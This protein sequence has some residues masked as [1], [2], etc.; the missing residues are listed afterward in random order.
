MLGAGRREELLKEAERLGITHVLAKPVLGAALRNTM[1]ALKGQ[2]PVAPDGGRPSSRQSSLLESQLGAIAGA[3][4]LLVEDNENNQLVACELLQGAGLVVD[5]AANGK[6]AV[7]QVE[8]RDAQHMPYDLVLM[9]MQMPVMDGVTATRLL[10]ETHS[11]AV[12]PIVAMT[13]NAMQEYR[14]RCLQAGMNAYVSKPVNPDE[15]WRALLV[16]IQPRAGLGQALR[17]SHDKP[18]PHS[19]LPP[20]LAAA[21]AVDVPQEAQAALEETLQAAKMGGGE[22]RA[23]EPAA[24]KIRALLA[25]E[26]PQLA[27]LWS[28]HVSALRPAPDD[29]GTQAP[30]AYNQ[31]QFRST[32]P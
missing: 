2:L 13:A 12:L 15:L 4:I 31:A 8:A 18:V 7:H 21:P 26:D 3:R 27:E 9:D 16:H 23:L 17:G 32:A 10:R 22:C 25:Q 30:P 5:V 19:A 1:L 20:G 14:E 11:P 6:I 29:A 28:A 24:Q